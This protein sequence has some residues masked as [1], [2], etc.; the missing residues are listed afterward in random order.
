MDVIARIDEFVAQLRKAGWKERD[1]IKEA[2]LAFCR[3]HADDKL[4]RHLEESRKDLPLE[5][6]WEVEEV[7]E[8]LAPEP[9]PEP[10]PE[11]EEAEAPPDDGQLRMSDLKEVYA[12]PRGLALYTDKTGQRWFAAQPDPYTGQTS[13]MEIPPQQVPQIKAQ[14]KGS[15][16][17]ALGSG[18]VP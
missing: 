18:V 8:A 6:R 16:Y 17:W 9:E 5:V 7:L 11:E 4:V 14:L 10:E 2:L 13:L 1:E 12:D 3:E 15:P